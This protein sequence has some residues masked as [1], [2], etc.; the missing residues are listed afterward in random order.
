MR[1]RISL[2]LLSFVLACRK[3]PVDPPAIPVDESLRGYL[4]LNE[5]LFQQNNASLTYIRPQSGEVTTDFFHAQNSRP[6]GDTGNDIQGYGSK[7]YVVVNVSN[8]VEVLDRKTGKSLRQIPFNHSSGIGKQPRYIAFYNGKILVSCYDGYVDV[9]DTLHFELERRVPVG[10]NPEQLV[11]ADGKLWVANSGGL[12]FP[13]VDSTVSVIDLSNWQEINRLTVGKNPG[14]IAIGHN[15][16][17]WVSVRGDYG[18]L[19]PKLVQIN[20]TTMSIESEWNNVSLFTPLEN[21]YLWVR[22][23]GD[24]HKIQRFN[25]SEWPNINQ[26]FLPFSDFQTLYSAQFVP[27]SKRLFLF[28]A[29]GYVNAGRLHE[30]NLSGQKLQTYTTGLIPTHLYEIQ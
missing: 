18:S 2:F 5:G 12:S 6:L 13:D 8:S 11:V 9:L 15:G 23:I 16:S 27:S 22:K 7:I 17:I 20:T 4:V 3:M 26:S 28:D 14:S 21:D 29:K 1:F 24:E 25:G 10:R 19:P 30:Y